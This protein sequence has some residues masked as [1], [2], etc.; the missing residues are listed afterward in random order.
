MSWQDRI[1][2]A[3]Y[4][5]PSGQ[6]F[7]GTF[8]DVSKTLSK[9]STPFDFPDVPGTYVQD[10]GPRGRRYPL[11]W[12]F[13]GDDYD[14]EA[15]RFDNALEEKGA[16]QL[17]HPLY[18]GILNVVPIGDITR[19]DALKTAGNQA[20]YNIEFWE[21]IEIVFPISELSAKNSI[22]FEIDAFSI[23]AAESFS[24]SLS[25]IKSSEIA[26][27]IESAQAGL[28][29]VKRV[30]AKIAA[31]T[32]AINRQF[33]DA[34]DIIENS[35]DTLVGTPTLLAAQMIQL[36]RLP[37]QAA[38]S[39]GAKLDSYATLI[40][41]FT[42]GPDNQ[43]SPSAVDSQPGN[44]F[45]VS[46]ML[47]S[48]SVIS[49]IESTISD[50]AIFNTRAATIEAIEALTANFDN[51]I[52]WSDINRDALSADL[53]LNREPGTNDL[54]DTGE[55]YQNLQNALGIASGRLT[56][57]VFTALQ[58]RSVVLDRARSIYDF[59]AEFYGEIDPKIDFIIE[60]NK[61]TGAEILELPK[62]RK[63]LY[64]V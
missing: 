40:A 24:D 28:R 46:D 60:S 55:H 49:S 23:S 7:V 14:I 50:D 45:S 61:L 13:W 36:T 15:E 22:N 37:S 20:V 11:K 35:I 56:E 16:G 4:T 12:I 19:V 48:A 62:D 8:E 27:L 63:M 30:M 17:L 5:S 51:Y 2:E 39:I 42:E 25:A 41:S 21:T 3:I 59:A 31:T 64:Y 10:L 47:A 38:A 1:T 18:P 26:G 57:I 9:K 44:A 53:S 29:K 52:A 43:F 32:E 54:I 6:E 58:E 34:V 33:T